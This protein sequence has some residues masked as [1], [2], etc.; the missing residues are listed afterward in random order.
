MAETNRRNRINQKDLKEHKFV[1]ILQTRAEPRGGATTRSSHR[2]PNRPQ[3]TFWVDRASSNNTVPQEE[4]LLHPPTPGFSPIDPALAA[5][6][7]NLA[8]EQRRR[9]GFQGEQLAGQPMLLPPVL[10]FS[11]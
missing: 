1:S 6:E 10:I 11:R 7:A 5:R 8:P 3:L 4:S 9:L 2:W